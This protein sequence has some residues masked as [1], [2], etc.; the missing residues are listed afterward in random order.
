MSHLTKNSYIGPDGKWRVNY[1]INAAP[2]FFLRD[3]SNRT[4]GA[5]MLNIDPAATA[6]SPDGSWLVVDALGIGFV[7]VNLATFDMLPFAPQVAGPGY[8]LLPA[9]VTLS[10]DGRFAAIGYTGQSYGQPYFT[11]YDLSTCASATSTVLTAPLAC[12][13]RNVWPYLTSQFNFRNISGVRFTDDDDI[14]FDAVYDWQSPTS[15][16]VGKFVISDAIGTGSGLQ[17]LA[18][19]DSYISGEGT[20][21][22]KLGT[23]DSNNKCHLSSRSYPYILGADLFNSFQS[24]ACSGA[25]MN[26]ITNDTEDYTGQTTDKVKRQYRDITNVLAN[27][28]PG[29]INQLDFV[30]K[31]KPNII[32]VSIGGNDIGF[33]GIIQTCALPPIDVYPVSIGS[34]T[35]FNT[36]DERLELVSSIDSQYYRLRDTYQQI[37]KAAAPGASV[38]VVGYPQIAAEGNC[39]N[40]VHLNGGEIQFSQQLISYLDSVVERAAKS[41]GAVY[42]DTQHA[43]DG[44][45]LCEAKSFDVA[46]NGLTAGND[47]GPIG[48]ESYHP[49]ALGQELLSAAVIKATDSLKE[50]MPAPDLTVPQPTANDSE[51]ADLLNM[52]HSGD[53]PAA[54]QEQSK[55][56]DDIVGDMLTKGGQATVTASG[57]QDGLQPNSSYQVVLHS[58][59]IS[60]GTFTTDANGDLAAPITVPAAIAPGTHTLHIYGTNLADEPV[61][62]YKT[63]YIA[64]DASDYDGDGIANTANSCLVVPLSGQDVDRDGIDDA[65]DPFI[66][67][68]PVLVS[69]D[70]SL[71]ASSEDTDTLSP[72][73]PLATTA[74]IV[75]S[76][77]VTATLDR[78]GTVLGDTTLNEAQGSEKVD[79]ILHENQAQSHHTNTALGAI[80]VVFGIVILAGCTWLIRRTMNRD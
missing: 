65:C 6:Y 28:E 48:K 17:Y 15:Y 59:P 78:S 70:A 77:P 66:G 32:T 69:P 3:G 31:Y 12:Q 24:V 26:D 2:D 71:T 54:Q 4:G 60:L 55:V 61:D 29:Y 56:D 49:N 58:S 34:S 51:A 10:N 46:V 35:C 53:V 67:E 20:F 62:I 72:A 57:V 39:A 22:Y 11:I 30:T 79:Q 1:A 14:S 23:D 27:F 68:V 40:N 33:A 80:V 73:K 52:P 64:A 42:V 76:S 43:F 50:A 5:D 74:G 44:H 37:I 9:G 38:Y 18:L 21:D 75:Q 8:S 16:S 45:R 47:T 7:R 19:G 13:S 25:T 41:A 63:V 36:Y